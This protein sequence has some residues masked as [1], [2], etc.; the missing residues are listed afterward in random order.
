MG[1]L[2]FTSSIKIPQFRKKIESRDQT[3]FF[4][5]SDSLKHHQ[6][7]HFNQIKTVKS[8]IFAT[9]CA[10]LVP[11]FQVYQYCFQ[12]LILLNVQKANDDA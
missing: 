2:P 1:H 8:L 4:L 6:C 3:K 5:V 7:V 11:P 9:V 10:T 12:V